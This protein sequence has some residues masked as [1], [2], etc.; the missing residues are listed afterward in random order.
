M[1][2]SILLATV[3]SL[4]GVKGEGLSVTAELDGCN[5]RLGD[6]MSVTVSFFAP[7]GFDFTALRPPS[8]APFLDASAWRLDKTAPRTE[9]NYRIPGNEETA[10]GRVFTYGIRPVKEGVITFPALEFS[11][12]PSQLSTVQLSTAPIPVHVKPAPLVALAETEEPDAYP[13]PDGLFVEL[14]ESAE[15]LSDDELFAWRKACRSPSVEAFEAFDFPE[16]RLNEAACAILSENWARALKIY[17]A[18]EWRIGQTP[19]IERGIVAALA[20][21]TQNP[22]VELPVWRQVLRPLLRF[23]LW[24]RVGIA[25]GGLLLIFLVYWL[26]KRGIRAVAVLAFALLLP[27]ALF[28]AADPFAEMERLRQQ[29]DAQ[30]NAM[31][32]GGFAGGTSLMTIN[33]QAMPSVDIAARV[34]V[35]A[36]KH[37]ACETF[38]VV[39]ELE[40]PKTCTVENLRFSSSQR[41]GFSIVGNGEMLTDG[42]SA[43]PSNVVRRLAIPIRYDVP[44]AGDVA[45]E[46]AGQWTSRIR[47]DNGRGGSWS[48][49]VSR[50]FSTLT[51]PV[52]L[53]ISLPSGDQPR[54]FSGAVGTNFSLSQT[55]DRTAVQTNEVV[56]LDCR[57]DFRG[58]LPD[59]LDLGGRVQEDARGRTW[60]AFKRYF[61]ADGS[62]E[63]ESLKL[64]YYDSAEKAYKTVTAPGV[65][66]AYL[67][68]D[69]PETTGLVYVSEKEGSSARRLPL[70][71]A[72]QES[73]EEIGSLDPKADAYRVTEKDGLW[74]R[75]ET[76]SRAGWVK[77]ED[78]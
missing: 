71:F 24:G 36:P 37:I 52:R 43:N 57:L 19:T 47:Q 9:T 61:V 50:S 1:I 7:V 64:V 5:V 3:V 65:K 34:S 39:L 75:V 10:C 59:T 12:T 27:A 8:L 20:V 73:A 48:S 72:P 16:A 70:R 68:D 45:F 4:G 6:P 28:A 2:A 33:G 67:A 77:T 29:M 46:V 42:A 14:K 78:L 13:K 23:A 55:P 49:Q 54:D 51:P 31:F 32:G 76:A 56:T 63:T 22:T 44:F 74:S 21:K 25:V 60:V 38:E 53:E 15:G 17:S 66:L 11:Y 62:P 58:F 40:M 41:V 35:E 26:L 69:A 30:M 18:L